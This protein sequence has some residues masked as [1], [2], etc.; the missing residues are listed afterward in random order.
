M[1]IH[2]EIQLQRIVSEEARRLRMA[3]NGEL[4]VYFDLKWQKVAGGW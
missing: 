4:K 3:E 2:Y 1:L